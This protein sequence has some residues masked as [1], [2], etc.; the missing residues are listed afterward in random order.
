M[1]AFSNYLEDQITGWLNGSAFAAQLI[2]GVW[3]Q[4]YS[5]SPGE[6]GSS[7]GALYTRVNVASGG[8]TRGTGDAGTLTNTDPIVI[9]SSADA[10]ATATYV[11]VFDAETSGNMLFYGALA[12]SKA[13]SIGDE[14]RFNATA[15][16]LTVA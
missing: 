16:T 9:T 4:L 12:T 8:F 10:A 6:G 2:G 5:Q 1:A 7:T 13:I 11:G 3:V 14:V 15:L